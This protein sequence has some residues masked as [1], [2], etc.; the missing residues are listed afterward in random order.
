MIWKYN[1]IYKKLIQLNK[2]LLIKFKYVLMQLLFYQMLIFQK[3]NHNFV[4]IS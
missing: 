3:D 4:R 1:Q 2:N